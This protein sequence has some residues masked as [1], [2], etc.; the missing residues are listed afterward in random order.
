M[1][2][3]SLISGLSGKD[4]QNQAGPADAPSG[5]DLQKLAEKVVEKL[6][7]ELEI[8]NERLGYS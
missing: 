7:R 4:D 1:P 8:E 6:R 2:K 3:N 5:V